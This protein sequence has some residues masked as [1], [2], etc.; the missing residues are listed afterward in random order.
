MTSLNFLIVTETNRNLL[1]TS[2]HL[3]VKFSIHMIPQEK[4]NLKRLLSVDMREGIF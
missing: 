2:K 3:L 1:K 4:E